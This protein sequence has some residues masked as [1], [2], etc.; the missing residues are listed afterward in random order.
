CIDGPELAS[1]GGVFEKD[2]FQFCGPVFAKH[3]PAGWIS[4]AG[5]YRVRVWTKPQTRAIMNLAA[6]KAL[7]GLS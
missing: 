6:A 2:F 5:R 3:G 4:E 7:T 1:S